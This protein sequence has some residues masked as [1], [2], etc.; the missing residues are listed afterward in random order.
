MRSALRWA[1]WL[2]AL[3]LI[4]LVAWLNWFNLNEAFGDGPPY[5]GRTTNMDK[6]ANPAPVLI[7]LD[8]VTA[9]IAVALLRFARRA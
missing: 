3:A 9:V 1:C 4:G 5:Y 8:A 2:A 7:A 6:W